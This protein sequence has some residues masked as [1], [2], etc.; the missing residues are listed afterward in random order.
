MTKPP[1]DIA[2]AFRN[3]EVAL[4]ASFLAIRDV[5]AHP[6]TLGDRGGG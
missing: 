4:R 1:F 3:K 5:T 6:T 2:A